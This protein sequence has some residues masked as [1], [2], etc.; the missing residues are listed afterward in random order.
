[1][2][3]GVRNCLCYS[4]LL[5]LLLQGRSRLMHRLADLMESNVANLALL[6]T[7]DSGKPLQQSFTKEIP[8]AIDNVRYFAG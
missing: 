5:L 4:G 2:F 7:L 1:V 3:Q 8:L 6:E